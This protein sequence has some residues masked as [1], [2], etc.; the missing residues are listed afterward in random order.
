MHTYMHTLPHYLQRT[1]IWKPL[2]RV[3]SYLLLPDPALTHKRTSHM[4]FAKLLFQKS[5]PI[6]RTK[7]EEQPTTAKWRRA[8]LKHAKQEN[9][10][11]NV[12][13]QTLPK[14]DHFIA[15]STTLN[16]ATQRPIDIP[17]D[18]DCLTAHICTSSTSL[19]CQ[20]SELCWAQ[21]YKLQMVFLCSYW[22]PLLLST[23]QNC[24]SPF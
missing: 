23:D 17:A 19:Q 3:L 5:R 7:L 20:A 16:C 18:G 6:L 10:S 22:C 12:K 15:L 9:Q 2:M 8:L 11:E 24:V 4:I 21:V 1:F 14:P 13:C